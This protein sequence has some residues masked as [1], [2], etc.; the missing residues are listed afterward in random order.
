[1]G[2][3]VKTIGM[4]SGAHNTQLK[5]GVNESGLRPMMYRNFLVN[6]LVALGPPRLA[7]NCSDPALKNPL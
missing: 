2:E 7:T 1:M 4:P 5:L 3:T 6:V